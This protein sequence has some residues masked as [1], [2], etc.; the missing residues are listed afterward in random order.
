MKLGL[1]VVAG[2]AVL[3]V[4][5][6]AGYLVGE[7]SAPTQS[8]AQD[9]EQAAYDETFEATEKQ[10]AARAKDAGLESG[11]K[12]GREAGSEDGASDA[13]AEIAASQPEPSTSTGG[14]PPGQD[15]FGS[16]PP[17]IA[18]P[19]PGVAPEYDYCIAQGGTPSPDGCLGI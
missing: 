15:A 18:V 13:D 6:A 1:L 12:E 9:A 7:S 3:M 10:A 2:V 5:G 16:T 14:C 8:E 17:C 11:R 4:V 19:A